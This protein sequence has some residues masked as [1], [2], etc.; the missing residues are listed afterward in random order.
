METLGL[1]V[2]LLEIK[3]PHR[4]AVMFFSGSNF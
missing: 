4:K 3:L 2:V 1:V